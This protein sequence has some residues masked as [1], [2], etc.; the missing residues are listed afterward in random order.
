MAPAP[1]CASRPRWPTTATAIPSAEW[2]RASS[3]TPGTTRASA[4]TGGVRVP[5]RGRA[6]VD[7]TTT[8]PNAVRWSIESPHLYRLVTTIEVAGTPVDDYET[9]FGVRT[10]QFDADRGFFLNGEHVELRGTCNHQDHA[11]VGSALPDRLQYYRIARLKAMG[12]NAYRTSH[13]PPTP[14]LLDACDRLGML[15]LDETRMFSSSPE[16]LSQFERLIRRDRNHA[17]RVL[18]VDRQRGAAAGH[19]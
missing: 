17:E 3:T 14:E 19:R 9:T 1:G 11:G 4:V 10:M 15:V 18:L 2:C 12:C 6:T 5:A 7:Q 16:G 8:I 13:N